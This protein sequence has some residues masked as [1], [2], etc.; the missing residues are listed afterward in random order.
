MEDQ[1]D[2]EKAEKSQVDRISTLRIF[3]IDIVST[4][5]RHFGLFLDIT[6]LLGFA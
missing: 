3:D 4:V 5:G 2:T 1:S 6:V